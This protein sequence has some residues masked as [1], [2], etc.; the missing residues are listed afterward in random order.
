[1]E[2]TAENTMVTT[3]LHHYPIPNIT[4]HSN[5]ENKN[6]IPESLED[7]VH[8][9]MKEITNLTE[10]V[11]QTMTTQNNIIA[12]QQDLIEH[13]QANERYFLQALDI[14]HHGKI[15]WKIDNYKK[16][17]IAAERMEKPTLYSIPAYTEQG[18]YK[19]CIR[20]SLNGDGPATGK[21]LSIYLNLMRSETDDV[22]QW[23]FYKKIVITLKHRDKHQDKKEVF[24]TNCMIDGMR[25]PLSITEQESD[26]NTASGIREF[27]SHK[28]IQKFIQNDSIYIQLEVFDIPG[29][30][31]DNLYSHLIQ[32]TTTQ[33]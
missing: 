31:P 20:T 22:L 4:S 3:T 13:L 7:Q 26:M 1:M 5:N 27:I 2:V 29:V 15:I 21:F 17:F 8:Y 33:F 9:T 24:V 30:L 32:K 19:F 12:K 23:P 16:W 25:Q 14:S 10:Y 11:M 6:S 28:D 18:G